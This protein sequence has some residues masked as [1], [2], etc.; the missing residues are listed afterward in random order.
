MRRFRD[1]TAVLSRKVVSLVVAGT[2]AGATGGAL[3]SLSSGAQARPI[4]PAERRYDFYAGGLPSCGDPP[5]LGRIQSRFHERE[6]EFWKSG[7]EILGFND[8]REI[9][10]RTNGLDYIPRR[11]CMAR[12]YLNNQV[13]RT[14][15]YAIVED[16]GIF[17]WG[18]GVDWCVA[19]L[20]RNYANAPNCAMAR[21]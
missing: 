12:A 4:V 14:V 11:Y 6:A 19:G 18:F 9:G 16:Q 8:V 17:G 2:I 21:P 20:D 13:V 15:S 5:V 3:A 1:C 10:M 7:L